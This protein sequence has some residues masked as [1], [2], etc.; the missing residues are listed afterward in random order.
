MGFKEIADATSDL[1]IAELA[2]IK[3]SQRKFDK[4]RV[5][6]GRSK[7][8]FEGVTKPTILILIGAQNVYNAGRRSFIKVIIKNHAFEDSRIPPNKG[9]SF[10]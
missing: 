1:R 3:G 8:G 10:R 4:E 6:V 9:R 2:V 7:I 5:T